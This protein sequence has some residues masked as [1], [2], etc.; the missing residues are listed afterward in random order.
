LQQYCKY[1]THHGGRAANSGTNFHVL[2]S[3]NEMSLT[4]VNF[5]EKNAEQQYAFGTICSVSGT[6]LRA[7]TQNIITVML[8]KN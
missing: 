1:G 5:E 7:F 8:H 2:P 6:F 3:F 4:P